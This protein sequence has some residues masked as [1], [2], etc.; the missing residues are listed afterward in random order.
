MDTRTF[1]SRPRVLALASVIT[2]GLV[3]LWAGPAAAKGPTS[4]TVEVDGRPAV[5][6]DWSNAD[7]MTDLM[8]QSR[9]WQGAMPD[10]PLSGSDDP[11]IAPDGELGGLATFRFTNPEVHFEVY[12]WAADGPVIHVPGGQE[13]YDRETVDAWYEA[14]PGIGSTLAKL[15]IEPLV[16]SNP[17]P[18]R[19]TTDETAG[20]PKDDAATSAEAAP[21]GA[22]A[23]EASSSSGLKRTVRHDDRGRGALGG[24]GS[25]H[26][27][28]LAPSSRRRGRPVRPSSAGRGLKAIISTWVRATGMRSMTT[29]HWS[30]ARSTAMRFRSRPSCAPIRQPRSDLLTSSPARRLMRRTSPRWRL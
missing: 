11:I 21:A 13:T 4:I 20:A 28:R 6:V 8:D 9:F 19:G 17:V 30:S 26:R 14:P 16:A 5:R 7:A 29:Q 27:S 12:P 18:A 25:L 1:I 15:G 2:I 24:R 10:G 23:N 22:S 3:A